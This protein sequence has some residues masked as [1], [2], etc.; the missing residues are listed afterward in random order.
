MRLTAD[1][2][3]DLLGL[4]SATKGLF[5]ERSEQRRRATPESHACVE[6]VPSEGHI[7]CGRADKKLPPRF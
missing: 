4:A 5:P 7:E 2:G 1:P 3:F 6:R